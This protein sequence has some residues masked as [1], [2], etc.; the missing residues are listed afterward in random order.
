MFRE[1]MRISVVI[2]NLNSPIID[3]VVQAVLNQG[4]EE[5]TIWV[6]GQD[7]YGKIPSHPLVHTLI[8]P[9][10]VSPGE[11][12]NLGAER[13]QA[14]L[15]IFL[16]ADCIPQSGWLRA[17][18]ETWKVHLDAGAISGAM[19]PYSSNFVR[20]CEQIARFHE[21]IYTNHFEERDVL[22]SFSLLVPYE[23][24]KSVGGFDPRLWLTEDL[25]FTL[26][27]RSHGW[28]LL[29]EPR[30]VVYHEPNRE[31]IIDFLSYARQNGSYSIRTRLRYAGFYRVSFWM[32]WAWF[33]VLASP[34][35]AFLRTFQIY[36]HTPGLWRYGCCGPLV[37]LHKMAWCLG[38]ADGLRRVS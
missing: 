25:D 26:R 33:W 21:Y 14:D 17:L 11:A 12:R 28:K 10:P 32:H 13:S 7:R 35:I 36:I 20:N 1:R 34:L 19:L 4:D 24:W 3:R 2:P 18:V 31:N 16:D 37:F 8:T 29:F 22:A 6:V 30:A 38:A 15:L 27:L 5:I 9:N 23:A